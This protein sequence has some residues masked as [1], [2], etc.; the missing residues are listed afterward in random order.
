[1]SFIASLQSTLYSVASFYSGTTEH[2]MF[3]ST[4]YCC[5]LII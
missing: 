5:S 1:M 4:F 2:F 3:Y